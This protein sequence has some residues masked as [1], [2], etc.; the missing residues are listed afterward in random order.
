MISNDRGRRSQRAPKAEKQAGSARLV[1]IVARTKSPF[2]LRVVTIQG[3]LFDLE[4]LGT[5]EGKSR[6]SR[7]LPDLGS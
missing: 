7:F 6:E 4:S 5:L 3:S 1:A 2:T